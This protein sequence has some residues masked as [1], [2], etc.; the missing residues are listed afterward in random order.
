MKTY[1]AFWYV[2]AIV[3]IL[4]TGFALIYTGSVFTKKAEIY[5]L[6]FAEGSGVWW[7]DTQSRLAR[8]RD[9]YAK[10]N[11]QVVSFSVATGLE[12]KN[13][14]VQGNADV[15]IVASAPLVNSASKNEEVIV[16]GSYMQSSELLSLVARERVY[17]RWW[18]QPIGYVPGTISEFYLFSYL[19]AKGLEDLYLSKKLNLVALTPS[20]IPTTFAK[21]DVGV[22][23]IWEP[24]ASQMKEAG[25][26]AE[27]LPNA[28]TL[29]T[30][31]ITSKD[32][33]EQR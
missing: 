2:S 17:D 5:T 4:G 24:F 8:E 18:E 33:W 3:L 21:E 1:K 20:G 23:V 25:V 22:A 7:S 16:L 10:H 9:L 13:A 14:V 6:R 15:G 28:Y 29:R 12:S 19:K 31:I 26:I 32:A 30:Y 27:A 11:L